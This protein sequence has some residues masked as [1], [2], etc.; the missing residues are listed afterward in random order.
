MTF[1]DSGQLGIK[2]S[3]NSLS[4]L[5]QNLKIMSNET[6]EGKKRGGTDGQI[7]TFLNALLLGDWDLGK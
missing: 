7:L 4:S 6:G 3:L 2:R 1:K 5:S